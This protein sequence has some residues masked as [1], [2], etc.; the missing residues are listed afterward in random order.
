M[1]LVLAAVAAIRQCLPREL[2]VCPHSASET[3]SALHAHAHAHARGS[4][5]RFTRAI[6]DVTLPSNFWRGTGRRGAARQVVGVERPNSME[7]DDSHEETRSLFGRPAGPRVFHLEVRYLAMVTGV[8][9]GLFC[10]RHLVS[11]HANARVASAAP[12]L[13]PRVWTRVKEVGTDAAQPP[14][15]QPPP[16]AQLPPEAR[17][18]PEGAE[19][20][21]ESW[22]EVRARI[23]KAQIQ[24]EADAKKTKAMPRYAGPRVLGYLYV[25]PGHVVK[26]LKGSQQVPER[27]AICC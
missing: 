5:K 22:E 3:M 18:P 25:G 13:L 16:E 8:L 11:S 12:P 10:G 23:L 4:A 14:E 1:R 26:D 20:V 7:I 2:P 21:K 9:L 17:P 15:A 6:D 19:P 24:M 27:A